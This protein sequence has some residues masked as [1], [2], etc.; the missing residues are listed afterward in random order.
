[1][2]EYTVMAVAATGGV[3]GAE[4]TWLRT[5]IFRL[6]AYWVSMVI[7]V[8]FQIVVDGWLT[9]LSSPIVAYNA[10]EFSGWRFPL[11]IPVEDFLFGFALVTTAILLWERRGLRDR[12]RE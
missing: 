12:S 11:D 2:R 9:K 7:V 6:K 10:D 8:G 4:L 3:V 1:M 5:G